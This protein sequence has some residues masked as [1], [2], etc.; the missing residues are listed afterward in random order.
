LKYL[1]QTLNDGHL[2]IYLS[3]FKLYLKLVTLD[4]H[5]VAKSMLDVL[6]SSEIGALVVLS[7]RQKILQKVFV[8]VEG[9]ATKMPVGADIERSSRVGC[10][11][12]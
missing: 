3:L 7:L 12:C 2:L 11:K 5:Q 4:Y 10:H 9:G 8:R 1:Y 6:Y